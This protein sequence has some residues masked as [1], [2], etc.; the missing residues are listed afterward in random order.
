MLS[1]MEQMSHADFRRCSTILGEYPLWAAQLG[2]YW[3][4]FIHIVPT[5]PKA[6][7]GTFLKALAQILRHEPDFWRSDLFFGYLRNHANEIDRKKSAECL[8]PLIHDV[9][10]AAL[11]LRN[12]FP[13][14][15]ERMAILLVHT[16]TPQAYFLLFRYFRTIEDQPELIRKYCLALLRKGDSISFNMARIVQD[17]F[18]LEHLPATFSLQLKPYEFGRLEENYEVFAKFLTA[19]K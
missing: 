10:D 13:E 17:Y 12:C 1:F 11:L 5:N 8:L 7:L 3:D 4:A 15:A 16:G 9:E 6:Y 18:A 2:L 19:A 14:S